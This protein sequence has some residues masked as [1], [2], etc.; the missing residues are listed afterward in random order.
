MRNDVFFLDTFFSVGPVRDPFRQSIRSHKLTC[1]NFGCSFSCFFFAIICG[2]KKQP[3]ASSVI[4]GASPAL[5]GA[6]KRS[7]SF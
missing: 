7:R 6:T 5:V 1:Q 3:F 4:P 2:R